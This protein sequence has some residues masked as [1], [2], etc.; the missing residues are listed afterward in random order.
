MLIK[1]ISTKQPRQIL[2]AKCAD[3]LPLWPLSC[4]GTLSPKPRTKA[5]NT[6]MLALPKREGKRYTDLTE[7]HSEKSSNW[8]HGGSGRLGGYKF[9][10]PTL[11]TWLANEKNI[12][13]R[14]HVPKTSG[15]LPL[16]M[17]I[18][19]FCKGYQDKTQKCLASRQQFPSEK[20]ALL[21]ARQLCYVC[22]PDGYRPQSSTLQCAMLDSSGVHATRGPFQY[23]P[24]N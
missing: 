4:S 24:M 2:S 7:L 19:V 14:H 6:S 1:G 11:C 23:G 18:N 13:K 5:G 12:G 21:E 3:S 8:G 9:W 16:K 17:C 15:P 22:R 20:N 10:L